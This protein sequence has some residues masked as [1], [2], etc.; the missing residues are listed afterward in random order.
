MKSAPVEMESSAKT[1]YGST[2]SNILNRNSVKIEN[3][4]I[5]VT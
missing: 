5:H 1:L 3:N 4:F 2:G